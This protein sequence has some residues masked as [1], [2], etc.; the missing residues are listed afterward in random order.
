MSI[1]IAHTHT[2]ILLWG[3]LFKLLIYVAIDNFQCLIWIML[4]NLISW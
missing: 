2:I 3:K 1:K 4:T